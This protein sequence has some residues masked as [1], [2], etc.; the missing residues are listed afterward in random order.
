[1]EAIMWSPGGRFVRVVCFYIVLSISFLYISNIYWYH[2][3]YH[4]FFIFLQVSYTFVQV[5]KTHQT[6]KKL[7]K[8][9]P[10]THART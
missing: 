4:I 9:Q 7:L 2:T 3:S 1:M 6:Y 10:R 8:V 5:L